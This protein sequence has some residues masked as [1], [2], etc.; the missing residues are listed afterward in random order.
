MNDAWNERLKKEYAEWLETHNPQAVEALSDEEIKHLIEDELTLTSAMTVE[1]YTLWQKWHEIHNKY[2]TQEVST[3]FGKERVLIDSKQQHIL[4][5]A[6]SMIWKPDNLEDYLKLEPDMILTNY[7]DWLRE[8]FTA[9]RTF[10]HTQRN[11]N[12]I[13]RNLFYLVVDKPT[14]KYLGVIVITGDFMDLTPRDNFI[15]WTREQRT[16]GRL[17]HTCIGSTIL[18][19]QPLGYNYV[20]GK[21]LAL[22]CLSDRVQREWYSRY[23]QKLVGVTTTSLYG[24]F[25][26][27]NNL[28]HWNKRGKSAGSIVFEPTRATLYKIRDWVH[29]KDPVRYWEWYFANNDKGQKLKRDHKFRMLNWV[30]SQLSIKDT[31]TMHQR[32]IYF[33]H[34][35]ENTA[36]FLREEIPETELIKRFDTT[37]AYLV[38]L[39][40]TKYASKRLKSLIESN[41]INRNTLFY[42]DLIYLSWEE[43]KEKYLSDVGR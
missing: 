17:N 39:W 3:L 2:P 42:D 29:K 18:P 22:L 38:D 1:E 43:T 21:L 31:K 14:G 5:K 11:N 12:N 24:S 16:A 19:T 30:Y 23:N 35:Y 32:G 36:E 25:S 37:T 28:K 34:L 20:G 6:K 33:S 15:G 10:V 4:A 13:G 26:Q 40:K 41:R 8:Q 9:I 27:Y 7:N